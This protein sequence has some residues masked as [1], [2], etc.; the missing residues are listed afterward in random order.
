[1]VGSA[2][3]TGPDTTPGA[4]SW[5][6]WWL[7]ALWIVGVLLMVFL[8]GIVVGMLVERNSYDDKVV[9]D[10]EWRDLGRVISYLETE[11]YYR[12]QGAEHIDQWQEAIEAGAIN[13]MLDA[14]G[15]AYARFLPPSEAAASSARLTGRYEGI[16]VSIGASEDEEVEIVSVMLNSPAARADVRV[17]D[18]VAE[19]GATPIPMADVELAAELLRGE[20]GTDVSLRLER[21]GEGSVRLDLTREVVETGEKTVGYQYYPDADLGVI[22]VTLFARTTVEE[23]DT[24]LAQAEE[25][26]VS[27]L[28]LD[29]RGNPGGWVAAAQGIIGRFVPEGAGPALLE[30]TRP[31]G[32]EML[33]LPI[34]SGEGD[35]YDGGLIVLVDPYTASAAEIVAGALQ[36]YD[37]AT[38]V[39]VESFGKGSVQRVYEF[40]GG[41]SLRLTVAEWFTPQGRP[42]QEAGIEPDV[43]L[44][45]DEPIEGLLPALDK[46]FGGA[47]GSDAGTP[48]EDSEPETVATP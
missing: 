24:A 1:M 27:R 39:G 33:N 43:E 12:P 36:D 32:G 9:L 41:E 25:D 30:D 35:I 28:V 20:A 4:Q 48:V 15:D 3:T 22:E 38:I 17:G 42:I 5:T 47:D 7:R 46:V 10:S 19:V 2:S 6:P 40:S 13:G 31:A 21:A 14:S 23:L 16:G 45:V 11:A 29:L 44:D 8:G 34:R 37:R 18:I 26:G